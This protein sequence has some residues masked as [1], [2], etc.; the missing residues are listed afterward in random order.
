MDEFRITHADMGAEEIDEGADARR[1]RSALAEIDGVDVFAIARIE[2]FQ[3]RHQSALIDIGTDV[4]E[5]EAPK[6]HA[7]ECEQPATSPS[8]A[9]AAGGGDTASV[10]C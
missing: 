10:P 2:V 3:H 1:Q 5:R 4:K 8:L 6:A 7:A 9:R